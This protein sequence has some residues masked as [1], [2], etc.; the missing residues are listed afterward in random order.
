VESPFVLSNIL[1]SEKCRIVS[2][3]LCVERDMQIDLSA[4]IIVYSTYN[5]LVKGY[6]LFRKNTRLL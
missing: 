4:V 6:D 1:C 2:E 3:S 5:Y